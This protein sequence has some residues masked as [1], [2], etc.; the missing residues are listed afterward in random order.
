MTTFKLKTVGGT[1]SARFLTLRYGVYAAHVLELRKYLQRLPKVQ[2]HKKISY[3]ILRE[4]PSIEEYQQLEAE[5]LKVDG[6]TL[7]CGVYRDLLA[8]SRR[9]LRRGGSLLT[10][11]S[12]EDAVGSVEADMVYLENKAKEVETLIQV[13]PALGDWTFEYRPDPGLLYPS[14]GWP[15]RRMVFEDCL[16]RLRTLAGC[17]EE[18]EVV[19]EDLETY[20]ARWWKRREDNLR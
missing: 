20:D 3:E 9:S 5:F 10:L 7:L 1:L 18:L 8:L 6:M 4:L 16:G 15:L 17:V 13:N 11:R 12:G 2:K 19:I 14:R